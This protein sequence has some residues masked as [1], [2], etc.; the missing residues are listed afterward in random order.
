M[1]QAAPV[2]PVAEEIAISGQ[3][4]PRLSRGDGLVQRGFFSRG[5]T[6][7]NILGTLGD[8]FLIQAGRDPIYRQRLQQDREAEALQNFTTDPTTAIQQ[9][10]QVNPQLAAQLWDRQQDNTRQASALDIQR[11]ALR[12]KQQDAFDD[13]VYSALGSATDEKSYQALVNQINGSS[14]RLGIKPSFDLPPNYDAA[15]VAALRMQGIPVDRQAQ[16]QDMREYRQGQLSNQQLAERGRQGR[17]AA[18]ITSR[19][20]EGQRNRDFRGTQGQLNRESRERVAAQRGSGGRSR[21]KLAYDPATGQ[22]TR[23]QQ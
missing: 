23:A 2:E 14:E 6:G 9:L 16:L 8:A 3:P 21:P 18:Q 19:E 5:R 22:I 15:R 17:T 1:G 7:G 12:Q 13:R 11:Q 4:L 10:N 20:R